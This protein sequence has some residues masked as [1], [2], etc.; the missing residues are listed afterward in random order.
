MFIILFYHFVTAANVFEIPCDWRIYLCD[1]LSI[2]D[3]CCYMRHFIAWCMCLCVNKRQSMNVSVNF[4]ERTTFRPINF[5]LLFF[6]SLLAFVW[7]NKKWIWLKNTSSAKSLHT[8]YNYEIW[9]VALRCAMLWQHFELYNQEE[10]LCISW[11]G[12][13]QWCFER[14]FISNEAY[15]WA[16]DHKISNNEI[17]TS[18]KIL[19]NS[20]RVHHA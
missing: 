9:C 10:N 7:H 2:L 17:K 6:S 14:F 15:V 16:F 13:A 20:L 19:T 5:L 3:R 12:R 4:I 8:V 1:S 18:F 11:P